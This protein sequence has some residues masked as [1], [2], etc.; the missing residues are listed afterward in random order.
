MFF[1]IKRLIRRGM[2]RFL[3]DSLQDH[4]FYY[5][6]FRKF[7]SIKSPV[8]FTERVLHRKHYELVGDYT[9]LADKYRVR[10][11]V[12]ERIGASYLVPLVS[13]M[14]DPAELYLLED[15]RNIVIK[16]NHAAGMVEIIGNV[17]PS[18]EEK[19]RIVNECQRWLTVD[20]STVAGEK[21][22]ASIPRRLVVEKLLGDGKMPPT[23]YKFH[24]FGGQEKKGFVLQVVHDRFS[25]ESKTSRGY[26][27]NRFDT[28]V[29]AHGGGNHHIPA[30]DIPLLEKAV[31]L[32]ARLSQGLDYVRIDW[33]V[34]NGRLYF[35]E[36]T[37]TP[38]AGRTNE[39]GDELEHLMG[40][41]WS[42]SRSGARTVKG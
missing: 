25:K 9:V 27:L 36:L 7:P 34:D 13:V 37:F 39:F 14:E 16:P 29:W 3:P 5:R 41:M 8:T 1:S 12:A 19:A 21:H 24:W 2:G 26:Y 17:L 30:G 18:D 38:G 35:G 31:E 11:F 20:F 23:D 42:V 33:Y 6:S 22:Y 10:E 15:W 4:I 40:E 28:C 32:N